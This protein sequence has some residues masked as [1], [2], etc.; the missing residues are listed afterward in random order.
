M[1]I[2]TSPP[3]YTFMV[4]CL[5]SLAQGQLYLYTYNKADCIVQ[6][7]LMVQSEW[8]QNITYPDIYKMH[9][10]KNDKR[11]GCK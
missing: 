5:I 9:Y 7:T 8:V 11:R 4:L 3:S 1:G 2:Y 6:R 10:Y